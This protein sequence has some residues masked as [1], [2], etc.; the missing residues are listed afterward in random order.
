MACQT[1]E[2]IALYARRTPPGESLPI[3][4]APTPIPD[5]VPTDSEVRDAVGE[6]TNGRSGGASKIRAEHMKEWLKGIQQEED[7][8]QSIGNQGA[9]DAW[10]LLMRLVDGVWEMGTIPQQLGWIIDV[11][12]PKGGGDYQGIGLPEPIWKIIEQVMDKQLNAVELR[13]SL[14]GC[15]SG[16]GTGTAIIE[17]KLAQNLAHLEQRPFFGVFLDLKKAF[18]SM[19]RD[20]CLLLLE[21]YVAGPNM[22]RLI[23]HFWENAQMVCRP[24]GKYGVPFKAG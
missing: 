12:I 20:R 4:I 22:R 23:C 14:H 9:G 6:L 3:N 19:D 21:G 2:R 7:P 13:K 15:R 16:R 18:D 17:A 11:L 10:R 5:G 8:K 1:E 24:S